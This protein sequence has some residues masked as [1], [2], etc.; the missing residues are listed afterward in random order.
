MRSSEILIQRLGHIFSTL[1][2]S[3]E[4]DIKSHGYTKKAVKQ[5]GMRYLG[6]P[7][8]GNWKVNRDMDEEGNCIDE[9]VQ[10]AKQFSDRNVRYWFLGMGSYP[11]NCSLASLVAPS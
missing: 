7:F 5:C 8:Y 11:Q 9:K 2:D 4:K 6:P 1:D 10:L 3:L